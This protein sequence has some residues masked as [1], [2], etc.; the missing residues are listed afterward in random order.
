MRR[1]YLSIAIGFVLP[2]LPVWALVL[3]GLNLAAFLTVRELARRAG[4]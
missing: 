4:E 2:F 1:I 3:A